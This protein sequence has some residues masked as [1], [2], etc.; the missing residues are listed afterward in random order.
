KS[1]TYLMRVLPYRRIGNVID[2]LV[3]TFLDVTQ[4]NRA[5]EQQARLA[6]IVESSQDAIVGRTFEGQILTWNN[7]AE[8]RFGYT[9]DEAMG[10][11][12]SLI[13]PPDAMPQVKDVHG[14][15]ERGETV[16]PFEAARTTRDGRRLTVSVAVSPLKD[17]AGR[18]IGASTIFRDI[19]E[20]K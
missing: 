17:A 8:K 15:L 20:L 14:R 19:T 1:A 10:R 9:A 7:A 12:V 11:S 5:L 3:L 4:L 18:L 13:V 6:A 2:G 16:A